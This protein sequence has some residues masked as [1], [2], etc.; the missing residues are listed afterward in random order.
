MNTGFIIC[1]TRVESTCML[2][3]VDVEGSRTTNI[4]ESARRLR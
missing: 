2:A 3:I 4:R 1:Q